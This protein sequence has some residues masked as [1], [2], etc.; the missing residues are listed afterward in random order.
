MRDGANA[1]LSRQQVSGCELSIKA[2]RATSEPK[3]FTAIDLHFTITGSQLKEAAV[4]R[5]V[6][7]SAEKYCSAS[8]MLERA[9]VRIS[10]SYSMVEQDA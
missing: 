8:I 7:L 9:G 4:K 10:H 1:L 6:E 3:V 2:E 5:A